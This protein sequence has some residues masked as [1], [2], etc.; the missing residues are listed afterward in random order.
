MAADIGE[1]DIDVLSLPK[2]LP[3]LDEQA[4]AWSLTWRGERFRL[5]PAQ[6]DVCQVIPRKDGPYTVSR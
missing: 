5:R 6:V 1:S 3:D 2:E 4:G